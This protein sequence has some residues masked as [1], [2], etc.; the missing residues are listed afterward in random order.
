MTD[1]DRMTNRERAHEVADRILSSA[2]FLAY[3][4]K[5]HAILGR[6]T[7]LIEQTV[8]EAV[9]ETETDRS[10]GSVY[11]IAMGALKALERADDLNYPLQLE[12]ERLTKALEWYAD[13]DNYDEEGAAMVA[14]GVT[15][16]T[17]DGPEHDQCWEP[18]CG[19]KAREALRPPENP[20]E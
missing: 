15:N 18:D 7:D 10:K 2:P 12:V 20:N 4:K 1:A 16:Y 5:Y 19:A 13:S 6:W 9:L 11:D 17:A 3:E 14:E 8:N